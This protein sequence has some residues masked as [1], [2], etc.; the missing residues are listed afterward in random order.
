MYWL[1]FRFLDIVQTVVN[2]LKL[3]V[4]PGVYIMIIA[5]FKLIDFSN[6]GMLDG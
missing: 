2:I 5:M 6:Y 4:V 3:P 1:F